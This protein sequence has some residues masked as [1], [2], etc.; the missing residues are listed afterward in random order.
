[1]RTYST[2]PH[3][4]YFRLKLKL[5]LIQ[6]PLVQVYP[7]FF[8]RPFLRY[9]N[10]SHHPIHSSTHH[11]PGLSGKRTTM[12]TPCGSCWFSSVRETILLD[13]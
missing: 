2:Q 4:R 7:F 8:L 13:I 12:A 6:N 10:I 11:V 3:P 9:M 5:R 1:M